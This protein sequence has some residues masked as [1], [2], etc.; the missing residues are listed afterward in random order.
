MS[1]CMG[2]VKCRRCDKF[3]SADDGTVRLASVQAARLQLSL[4]K[5]K[6][7]PHPL[8]MCSDPLIAS[9]ARNRTPAQAPLL[10]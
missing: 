7:E 9:L 3:A 2:F 1:T 10:L 8:V 4:D 6:S 5:N